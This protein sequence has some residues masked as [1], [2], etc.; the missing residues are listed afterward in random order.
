MESEI[1]CSIYIS[2]MQKTTDNL[3][4]NC[5]IYIFKLDFHQIDLIINPNKSAKN[6][7]FYQISNPNQIFSEK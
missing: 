4:K 3:S 2:F 7:N 6:F 5:K 1:K